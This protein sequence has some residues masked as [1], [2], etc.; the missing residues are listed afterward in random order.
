MVCNKMY[1]RKANCYL[2]SSIVIQ[3]SWLAYELA[4]AEADSIVLV[5]KPTGRTHIIVLDNEDFKITASFR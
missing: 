4:V 5:Q 1:Q 2:F 3:A